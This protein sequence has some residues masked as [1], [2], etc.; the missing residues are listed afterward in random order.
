[1]ADYNVVELNYFNGNDY[2][3]IRLHNLP[4]INTSYDSY[5]VSGSNFQVAIAE[6]FDKI[7]MLSI[8]LSKGIDQLSCIS[9]NFLGSNLFGL[10]VPTNFI[11]DVF[12][13]YWIP[14]Q[15]DVDRFSYI[16]ILTYA[17]RTP[18]YLLRMDNANTVVMYNYNSPISSLSKKID[19]ETDD[20]FSNSTILCNVFS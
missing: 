17:K 10:K 20:T 1:M 3:Y 18:N 11:P 6:S 9:V 5:G 4:Y 19:I 16:I 14:L 12:C 13:A 7:K 8:S 2:D 15:K